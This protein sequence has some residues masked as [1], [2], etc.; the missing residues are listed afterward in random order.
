MKKILLTLLVLG[1]IF[2]C[3][4]QVFES[5]QLFKPGDAGYK[6]YRI[7]ALLVAPDGSLLAFAEGRK[8]NCGDAG[9]IDLVLKRS[10]DG[11]KSWSALEIVWSDGANTCGNPA[12]V[13]DMQS[14]HIVLLSTWN[15]GEDHEPQII[16][17][18]SKDTRRIFVLRS[19]DN[20]RHWSDPKDITRD[21]KLPDWTWYATGPCNGI[22]IQSGP[23]KNRLVIPADHI[24]AGTKRYFSHTIHSDDGGR[25]WQLGGTTPTDQVN[26]CTVAE[27]SGGKLLLNMRNYS[28]NRIRKTAVST[29][30]G[31]SWSALQ[32]DS[33][34]V[35]PVCQ[36]SMIRS[37]YPRKGAV[38][39]FS[40]PAAQNARVNMTVKLS[41]DEGRSWTNKLVLHAG[42]AAYSNLTT[43]PNGNLACLYEAG[44][45]SPYEAIVFREIGWDEFVPLS[46]K[47]K[48]PDFRAALANGIQAAEG[49]SRSVRYVKAW[50]A[51]A[52]SETG[53]IPR[54][55]RESKDFWNA[56]DAAADNYPYMV[57]VSS[58]L[59]PD[60]FKDRAIQMLKQES[61]LTPRIGKLPDSYSFSKRSFLNEKI[62]THQIVFGAA[63]FMKDG[64]IPLTEW[65]G[66]S[67]W[68][69]RMLAMLDDLPKVTR[70]A[71]G[72]SGK[73]YGNSATVEVNGDLL[74]VLSR[75]YWFTGK[76]AYLDWAV[77]IA[78]AYLN[79]EQLPT[80]ALDHLR[81][82][83]H[84]CEII[85]GL[86]EVYLAAAYAMPHKRVQ[87]KPF[88]HQMLNRILEVGRNEDG[89]FYDEVDP[90]TGTVIA[91]RVADNFGY[92]FNAYW[93]IS[94][95][96]SVPHFREAVLKGLSVLQ[97]KYR[98]HNW[99]N[100]SADGYADAI[101][102]GLNLY[103]R[104]KMPSVKEWLDS[105][106]K[107]MWAMQ[108]PDGII[109]GW[110]GD[111]NFARTS[112]MYSLW[113][114]QGITPVGWQEGLQLGAV[115]TTTGLKVAV[116]SSRDWQGG[117][118]F[119]IQRHKLQM[120][121]PADY[122][123]IN[124][125]PEW[126]TV[127]NLQSY[128]CMVERTLPRYAK[129][130]N[131]KNNSLFSIGNVEY[132]GQQMREGIPLAV[133]A[134][135]VVWIEINTN[136]R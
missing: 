73:W 53:L 70:M 87:W 57:L 98:N 42:P 105:E 85:S 106:I 39:A 38:L 55:I 23:Y 99:E 124:Q 121:M 77:E 51:Y 93:F 35:E 109:E 47:E 3:R 8:N 126:F 107:V 118:R 2:N 11:G 71:K 26:E 69:D 135:E 37:N 62:D 72:I 82:R 113:K 28:G 68:S 48:D 97:K 134:G 45:Q 65:L 136:P 25:S 103:N 123:R 80:V 64:L 111:G 36:A 78:D 115:S 15:L 60:Y 89:L 83:D 24:E 84:G 4:S 56:W 32:G 100:G 127:D 86:C 16:D 18:K 46:A 120:G 96:D 59:M 17:G 41:M 67:P 7:P 129:P 132:T 128:D 14:G 110:H 58:I 79:A 40:N 5:Q 125:F 122:P 30:G 101:E 90:R 131:R 114:T 63:E 44:R 12:P 20:G 102:G 22:Q 74:Q 133:R 130:A 75:M 13:V 117:I 49:F 31:A 112:I 95:I 19:E 92:T 9:D 88:V 104:E 29:D 91:S 76:Q 108:Q 33:M 52:D 27:I 119:D 6:C 61:A 1:F 94:K 21:V 81:I 10:A 116:T 66:K 54:N 43:L 50:D 34:L